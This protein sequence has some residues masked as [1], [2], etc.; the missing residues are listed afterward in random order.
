MT[1]IYV[2][3]TQINAKT[4]EM[5]KK[6]IELTVN[7][8]RFEELDEQ[9]RALIEAAKEATRTSYAPYSK[10]SVGAALQLADGQVIKG[11]NQENAS[12]PLGLCAERT[13]LFYANASRPTLAV[14]TLAVAAWT[15]GR[16][17]AQPI[18]P[19]GACR[20][21]M[22]ETENRYK[23][24]IRVLLYGTDCVY[25]IARAAYL[26]PLSFDEAAL[27]AKT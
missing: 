19:C 15:D 5:K 12:Y 10:F 17:L 9:D 1:R 16:F 13:A 14:H 3:L 7:T 23:H 20:Q 18:T 22:L 24:P 8:Y 6:T 25:E 26:L 4:F 2:L 21:V 27:N 11:S